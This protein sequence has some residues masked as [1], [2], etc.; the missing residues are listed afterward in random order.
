MQGVNHFF[1]IK[2]N[3][4]GKWVSAVAAQVLSSIPP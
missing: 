2:K 4:G 1:A 3:M